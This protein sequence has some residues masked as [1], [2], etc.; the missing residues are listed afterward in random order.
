MKLS[1]IVPAYNEERTVGEVLRRL[2]SLP[3]TTEVIAVD[4]GSTDG[5]LASMIAAA[6]E[7]VRVVSLAVNRGK[8]HAVREGLRWVEGGAV[9]IQ[10]AD[11]ELAP[12]AL[13]ELARPVLDGQ[14]DAAFGSRFM[15]PNRVGCWCRLLNGLITALTNRLYGSRLTD[16]ACGHKVFAADAIRGITIVSEGFEFEAEVAAK[17]LA[18]GA[19]IV[20]LPVPYQP[21]TR[22]DG[23]KVRV[24]R[25]GF[26][27]VRQ[28]IR[29]RRGRR[30]HAAVERP[31][32]L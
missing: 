31:V 1:V 21:R 28:L 8:A 9:A 30:A 18:S 10:D 22:R 20:E 25:D 11:L 6:D 23:K 17:L 19:R 27:A 16:V 26:G 32:A 24:L 2:R 4:D 5:T 3:V 15:L 13:T 29:F 12:E 7:R 14:A